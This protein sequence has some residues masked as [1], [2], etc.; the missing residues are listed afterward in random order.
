M[1]R[2]RSLWASVGGVLVR[3]ELPRP[4]ERP[5]DVGNHQKRLLDELFPSDADDLEAA[6]PKHHVT[7]SVALEG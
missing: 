3:E 2:W 4:L 5:G 7:R 1:A 6:I